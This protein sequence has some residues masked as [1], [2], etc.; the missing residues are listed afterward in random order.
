MVLW[1]GRHSG[2]GATGESNNSIKPAGEFVGNEGYRPVPEELEA[3][4]PIPLVFEFGDPREVLTEEELGWVLINRNAW[5]PK[6]R[7]GV[8]AYW[9]LEPVELKGYTFLFQAMVW[10]PNGKIYLIDGVT[11][12]LLAS[13]QG[14]KTA[15]EIVEYVASLVLPEITDRLLK[16]ASQRE[17]A[18]DE[19]DFIQGFI[20]GLYAQL[21]LLRKYGLIT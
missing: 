19:S 15:R 17:E 2:A 11:Y 5:R 20:G 9:L 21:A 10:S 6:G 18:I 13:S 14:E 1:R 4:E 7:K 16:K 12:G 3:A 8:I